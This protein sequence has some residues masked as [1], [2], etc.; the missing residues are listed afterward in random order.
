MPL[1]FLLILIWL[2]YLL[3]EAYL[4]RKYVPGLHENHR[5]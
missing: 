1:L 4:N 5:H 3:L 2:F